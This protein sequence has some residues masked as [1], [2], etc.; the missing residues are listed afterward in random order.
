MFACEHAGV[1]PDI[2]CLSKALTAGYLPLGVTAATEAIAIFNR[3]IEA[4][5]SEITSA[6]GKSPD[7]GG[8]VNILTP[9]R[10]MIE[11][12]HAMAANS[13]LVEIRKWHGREVRS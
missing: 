4:S 13:C 7:I 1:S 10:M 11:N 9:R 3:A 8:C 2:L 6:P 12:S 5:R